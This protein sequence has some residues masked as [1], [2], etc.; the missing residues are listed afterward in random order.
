MKDHIFNFFIYIYTL[1]L[2][3]LSSREWNLWLELLKRIRKWILGST[4]S[5]CSL[6]HCQV[7][8]C[9]KLVRC[10]TW[11]YIWCIYFQSRMYELLYAISQYSTLLFEE[12]T[13]AEKLLHHACQML[14]AV[15]YS[16]LRGI[17][18]PAP[19]NCW[20]LKAWAY[21][22][23]CPCLCSHEREESWDVGWCQECEPLW[24]HFITSACCFRDVILS[25]KIVHYHLS[26]FI[27]LSDWTFLCLHL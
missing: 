4:Q 22:S 5:M 11:S 8:A 12:A 21:A 17:T 25:F 16:L 26:S 13:N 15:L 2:R 20:A 19:S 24:Q 7:G 10:W 9:K 23:P 27:H 6:F 1:L 14:Q 18:A 3:L